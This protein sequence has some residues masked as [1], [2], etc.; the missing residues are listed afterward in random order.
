MIENK[1]TYHLGIQCMMKIILNFIFII[2]FEAWELFKNDIEARG[3]IF[4]NFEPV[5]THG[6]PIQA[7]FPKISHYMFCYY[8]KLKHFLDISA[9]PFPKIEDAMFRT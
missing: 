8:R 9:D 5:A 2:Y 6:D 3:V 1:L 4:P 7:R